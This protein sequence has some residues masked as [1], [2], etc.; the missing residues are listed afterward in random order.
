MVVTADWHLK[1]PGC[2]IDTLYF[3]SDIRDDVFIRGYG[4]LSLI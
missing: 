3:I 2:E 4:Q 1:D